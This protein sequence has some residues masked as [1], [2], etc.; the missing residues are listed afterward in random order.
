MKK[1][2][3]LLSALLVLALPATA[4]AKAGQL[5]RSFGGTGKVTALLR[6]LEPGEVAPHTYGFPAPQVHLSWRADGGIAV[7]SGST[8]FKYLRNGRP[9]RSFGAGGRLTIEPAPGA[10]AEIAAVKFDSRGRLLVAGTVRSSDW[11][12]TGFVT[13]YLADGQ[14]DPSFGNGGTVVTTLGLPAPPIP[15]SYDL[16]PRAPPI[17]GP[18]VEFLGLAIDDADRPLLSGA[19][20]GELR[21]CYPF[22][23][24]TPRDTGFLA[25]LNENGSVDASFG[26]GGIL[27][28]PS[29]EASFSPLPDDRGLLFVGAQT[30]CIRGPRPSSDLERATEA[31][32]PDPSFGSGGRLTVPFGVRPALTRD[33]FDRILIFGDGWEGEDP[34]LQRLTPRGISDPTFGKRGSV[35]MSFEGKVGPAALA[36]D[37]RG[38]PLLAVSS[39]YTDDRAAFLLVR[40]RRD[41]GIDR[42]FWDLGQTRTYFGGDALPQQVLAAGNSKILVGGV[43]AR[44]DSYR[45]AL[46]RY[47][48]R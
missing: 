29:Q 36:V 10:T 16:F 19:W 7:G 3:C 8:L 31:G 12:A 23:Y 38:R 22:T 37:R 46:A 17:E 2:L 20:A 25:R 14:L 1:L 15:P 24:Y 44:P 42:S 40:R 41:G 18:M 5:D 39:Q 9:N 32:R 11:S 48:A 45:I 28:D 26:N 21:V 6:A 43:V 4:A 13:R 47:N 33:R 34:L 30:N 35:R 27:T